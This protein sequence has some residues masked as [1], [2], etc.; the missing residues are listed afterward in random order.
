MQNA[1]GGYACA[2]G[3][4]HWLSQP[5]EDASNHDEGEEARGEFFKTGPDPT[6]AFDFLE[7]VLDEKSMFVDAAID[8]ER[9]QAV[10]GLRNDR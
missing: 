1:N 9:C 3:C 5:N 10:G 8:D 6:R 7:K 2:R 4:S